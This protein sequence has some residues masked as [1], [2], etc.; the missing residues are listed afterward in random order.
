M[1]SSKYGLGLAITAA[2]LGLGAGAASA[3]T[4]STDFEAPTF[5]TGDVNGQNGWEKDRPV[6]C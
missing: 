2:C 4:V 6:R 3:D 5:A 1:R